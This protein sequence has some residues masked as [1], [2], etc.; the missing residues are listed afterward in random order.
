MELPSSLCRL[1]DV[2]AAHFPG[3]GGC[4]SLPPSIFSAHLPSPHNRC[5]EKR[6]IYPDD[7]HFHTDVSWEITLNVSSLKRDLDSN[8]A[9][10]GTGRAKQVILSLHGVENPQGRA[11]HCADS[12][13]VRM[14]RPSSWLPRACIPAQASLSLVRLSQHC[15]DPPK[16]PQFGASASIRLGGS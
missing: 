1:E 5:T 13:D 12:R 11:R 10:R 15:K 8:T 2:F 3:S 4:G 6:Y 9:S 14:D 16:T 7:R